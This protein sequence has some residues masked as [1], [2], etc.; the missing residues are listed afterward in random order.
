MWMLMM[1]KITPWTQQRLH[2]RMHHSCRSW[3]ARSPPLSCQRATSESS[4]SAILACQEV[5]PRHRACHASLQLS[6]RESTSDSGRTA[7]GLAFNRNGSHVDDPIM[8][9]PERN[10]ATAIVER[11]LRVSG[12]A[13]TTYIDLRPMYDGY[14]KLDSQK[15]LANATHAIALAK[16]TLPLTKENL[17]LFASNKLKI[18]LLRSHVTWSRTHNSRPMKRRRSC[19][20][21]FKERLH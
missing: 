17:I 19:R 12:F 11:L 4:F 16:T 18:S 3:M 1:T 20:S 7:S 8:S 15:R 2:R 5:R 13:P 10:T 21:S 14:K 9:A 6:R